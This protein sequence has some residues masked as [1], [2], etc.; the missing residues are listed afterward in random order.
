MNLYPGVLH[1]LFLLLPACQTPLNILAQHGENVGFGQ[2]QITVAMKH[3]KTFFF[4]S[5]IVGYK[6]GKCNVALDL[7]NGSITL[8][9]NMLKGSSIHFMPLLIQC[10]T[11]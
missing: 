5:I 7:T 1:I 6:R 11:T 8:T 9:R 10:H 2:Y 4:V 3:I